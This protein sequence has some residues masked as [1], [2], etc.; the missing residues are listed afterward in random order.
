MRIKNMA[1]R[2]AKLLTGNAYFV[3]DNGTKVEKINYP[4][5]AKQ[6]ITEYNTQTL[7]GK[8]QSVQSALDAI[9][10]KL[11]TGNASFQLYAADFVASA[12]GKLSDIVSLPSTVMR[13]IVCFWYNGYVFDNSASFYFIQK[14]SD[15]G[16]YGT[17]TIA[18]GSDGR[19]V[20][21]SSD[22]TISKGEQNNYNVRCVVIQL[23]A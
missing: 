16:F 6:I 21:L 19:T 15:G 22:G 5:L 9:N 4:E 10:G 18:K 12:P 14:G 20:N 1:I 11:S 7:A 2:T 3:I 23:T 8:A 13:M 17:Q